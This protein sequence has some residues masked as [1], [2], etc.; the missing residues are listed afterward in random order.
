MCLCEQY[1]NRPYF[2]GKGAGN[3]LYFVIVTGTIGSGVNG[4]CFDSILNRL[5]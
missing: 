2:D 1:I 5:G 3:G 4:A